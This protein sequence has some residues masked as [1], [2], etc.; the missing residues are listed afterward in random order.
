MKEKRPDIRYI[1]PFGETTDLFSVG[2]NKGRYES[3][4][5][6]VE[7][8]DQMAE[9]WNK[10]GERA[11]RQIWQNMG[12][13]SQDKYI[14]GQGTYEAIQNLDKMKEVAVW[15][16]E[17]IGTP[18]FMKKGK[19]KAGWSNDA[20][21]F[22]VTEIALQKY[23]LNGGV[24]SGNPHQEVSMFI[25]PDSKSIERISSA[26]ADIEQKGWSGLSPDMQRTLEAVSQYGE[27][28][29]I[30]TNNGITTIGRHGRK[31][32]GHALGREE[33]LAQ[34]KKGLDNLKRATPIDRAFQ[35]MDGTIDKNTLLAGHNVH[36]FDQRG[37]LKVLAATKASMAKD[38]KKAKQT[39]AISNLYDNLQR[40]QLDT[41]EFF[42][43][44]YDR[45]LHDFG[46]NMTL[47]GLYR[48]LTGRKAEQAH[49][50]LAD[51]KMNASL[52]QKGLGD[53]KKTKALDALGT[54]SSNTVTTGMFVFSTKGV[55][56][57]S[58]YDAIYDKD[59][60]GKFIRA[61]D[62][63][64]ASLNKNNMYE[65]V[66]EVQ[67][68]MVKG[69]RQFS[70]MLRNHDT[71]LY[72]SIVRDRFD[73]IA[74]ILQKNTVPVEGNG[75]L[76]KHLEVL[77]ESAA[78]DRARRAYDKLFD[79][80]EGKGT[81][82]IK[83]SYQ[84]LDA[85]ERAYAQENAD[86][87]SAA[88]KR[89]SAI[90]KALTAVNE[91]VDPKYQLGMSFADNTL[92]MQGR[93]IGERKIWERAIE[94]I[95]KQDMWYQGE[96][97]RRPDR[98]KETLALA[99]VK[100]RLDKETQGAKEL[101][102]QPGNRIFQVDVGGRSRSMNMTRRD[103]FLA[104]FNNILSGK[105]LTPSGQEQRFI[106]MVTQARSAEFLS[107][108]AQSQ[109][110]GMFSEM[111]EKGP[112]GTN[113]VRRLGASFHES[114]N[115]DKLPQELAGGIISRSPYQAVAGSIGKAG[116][117]DFF[118]RIVQESVDFARN[119]TGRAIGGNKGLFLS[120]PKKVQER[121]KQHEEG[122]KFALENTGLMKQAPGKVG[123]MIDQ[124]AR[125]DGRVVDLA[126]QFEQNG[127]A[128]RV[129]YA[130]KTGKMYMLVSKVE[131][132]ARLHTMDLREAIGSSSVAHFEIPMMNADG[133]VEI[134]GQRMAGRLSAKMGTN[135]MELTNVVDT[136][137]ENMTQQVGSLHKAKDKADALGTE[138]TAVDLHRRI[139]GRI[140]SVVDGLISHHG[141]YE[142]ASEKDTFRRSKIAMANRSTQI[143]TK[144]MAEQWYKD[145]Q[146]RFGLEDIS[147]VLGRRE[148]GRDMDFFRSMNIEAQ[149]RFHRDI[150]RYVNEELGMNLLSQHGI[151]DNQARNGIRSMVDPREYFAFGE[152]NPTARE[153]IVKG[154]NYRALASDASE[155]EELKQRLRI[156]SILGNDGMDE[157]EIFRALKGPSTTRR[158]REIQ[159]EEVS[160]LNVRVATTN[161]AT[162]HTMV[163]DAYRRV[164]VEIEA[165]EGK[166]DRTLDENRKL[167]DLERIRRDLVNAGKMSTHDG[168]MIAS[169]AMQDAFGVTHEKSVSVGPYGNMDARMKRLL[170]EKG[171]FSETG[172]T[173]AESGQGISFSE[174][175]RA[176]L[177]QKTSGGYKVTVGTLTK[178]END[179]LVEKVV[180]DYR[181]WHRHHEV[182]GFDAET[183]RVIFKEYDR[184]G[185]GAKAI[186]DAGD[187]NTMVFVEQ[188]TI[189]YVLNEQGVRV[190]RNEPEIN[191][192]IG[193][194][195]MSKMTSFYTDEIMRQALS[196]DMSPEVR[197]AMEEVAAKKG[198]TV[199]DMVK[200]G[201]HDE[202]MEKLMGGSLGKYMDLDGQYRFEEGRL[203]LNSRL[204][205]A[206]TTNG[207]EN[208]FR[209]QAFDKQ[210][211]EVTGVTRQRE[212]FELTNEG[213]GKHD[214]YTYERTG[215]VMRIGEKEKA[216]IRSKFSPI[217]GGSDFVDFIERE[218]RMS[219]SRE[220]AAE[221]AREVLD[222]AGRGGA[223]P[224][225][226]DLVID[227]SGLTVGDDVNQIV[228]KDGIDYVDSNVIRQT[229]RATA[230]DVV[231]LADEYAG[232]L[233]NYKGASALVGGERVSLGDA[234][235]KVAWMK[236]PH[237]FGEDR[238]V[239]LLDVSGL[240]RLDESDP[241]LLQVQKSQNAL[242]RNLMELSAV[243][244]GNPD[245][246]PEK[247][248]ELQNRIVEEA[249][250]NIRYLEEDTA[251][252]TSSARDGGL[253]NKLGTTKLESSAQFRA[254]TVNPFDNWSM[255]DGVWQNTGDFKEGTVHISRARMDEMIGKNVRNVADTLFGGETIEEL[256]QNMT[257]EGKK[258]SDIDREL[259]KK[260]LDSLTMGSEDEKALYGLTNRFPTISD[261]T[262]QATRMVI[263]PS[264]DVDDRRAIISVGTLKRMAGDTDGDVIN[265]MLTHYGDKNASRLHEVARK[266][267]ESEV[268]AAVSIGRDIM[269]EYQTNLEESYMAAKRSQGEI[270]A[271]TPELREE[272]ARE[273]RKMLETGEYTAGNLALNGF[274]EKT[275]SQFFAYKATGEETLLAN[276]ARQGKGSLGRIDNTRE[277]MKRL[278]DMTMGVLVEGGLETAA[279]AHERSFAIQKFGSIISQELISSKK[280]SINTFMEQ[281]QAEQ[282]ELTDGETIRNLA[283]ERLQERHIKVNKLEEML[284]NPTQEN[285][286]VLR[287]EL[288]EMGIFSKGN[289]YYNGESFSR[290]R[291]LQQGLDELSYIH[292]VNKD[293]GGMGAKALR[294]NR[295]GGQA[296]ME[297]VDSVLAGRNFLPTEAVKGVYEAAGES[298]LEMFE[299][300]RELANKR[301]LN[302]HEE[303]TRVS[304]AFGEHSSQGTYDM[305]E[306]IASRG[307]SEFAEQSGRALSSVTQAS[308]EIVGALKRGA[309]SPVGISFAAIWGASA[310][311]R[312]G[313]TPEGLE[314]QQEATQAEVDP[315]ILLTSPTARVTNNGEAQVLR[316]SAKGAVD[317]N[318]LAGIVNREIGEMTGMPMQMNLNVNDNRSSLD[319]HYLQETLNQALGR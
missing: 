68:V 221:I 209:V 58:A 104:Q 156:Q 113:E 31:Y 212:N 255:V 123:R 178:I 164:Q 251:R 80:H 110:F 49:L 273:V 188:S 108:E 217:K 267:Y 4:K 186:S 69:E 171:L 28:A 249:E 147:R 76:P 18:D 189:D 190:I 24:M 140:S 92:G 316:V 291:I 176:G 74:S 88:A 73:D 219:S 200:A 254:S 159:G 250:K 208:L 242:A 62:F 155:V 19:G 129:S 133:T 15:D 245:L 168:L 160:H 13:F 276:E 89:Q 244:N 282:P 116:G 199:K 115:L 225:K 81:N 270:K 32:G 232:T 226:G 257:D 33:G 23:K 70:L 231:F 97:G 211:A 26:I 302:R 95:E 236:L 201:M 238:H 149:E 52:L 20:D 38:P 283:E 277:A 151:S 118:E 22:S 265:S 198:M 228:R 39:K 66:S 297:A 150:D 202:A 314:A 183:G 303:L 10:P 103:D 158:A 177:V 260:V 138:F 48:N 132:A 112:L 71:G 27:G 34:V 233:A 274:D 305:M 60:Q 46:T 204:S 286:K 152:L 181:S 127:F 210:M 63:R 214:I 192:K 213:L 252:F 312:T 179:E 98:Y 315:S 47:G 157:D 136:F 290:E 59:A 223:G 299:N 194:G 61:Q 121:L 227:Y 154:M 146:K 224:S 229:R 91:G 318:A 205:G 292:E 77:K 261:T 203:V 296:S 55:G 279:G 262:M 102:A 239:R 309:V 67:E 128:A 114:V 56:G 247:R 148:K 2:G 43:T 5:E 29:D 298:A 45:P 173:R 237:M 119:H 96:G 106:Q 100:T 145:N 241:M 12:M 278:H 54:L 17:T 174:L 7:M 85:F 311:M 163:K 3:D 317:H 9:A 306:R 248:M 122:V 275:A 197:Q 107:E 137:F 153:N 135:G 175:E 93:L 253:I 187:R 165:L 90:Q 21:F 295:S 25:R 234:Q 87:L 307:G 8:A 268:G 182:T 266:A 281:I 310:L 269:T 117:Q 196:G 301:I 215:D 319:Q 193:G 141:R 30:T 139:Q 105:N 287:S 180:T 130:D 40:P 243:G 126:N 170:E 51:I 308:G 172:L 6:Y 230:K 111:R 240:S 161:E 235:E 185:Q 264:L 36:N 288:N 289:E 94:E 57:E 101:Y 65:V 86:G 207:E 280:L 124:S 64:T 82:R 142:Y 143:D 271:I 184:A 162:I 218:I 75:V 50:A 258:R 11:K 191:K 131:D 83:K 304:R 144:A 195:Y 167:R 169:R 84:F 220:P 16:M 256:V 259:R 109:L 41:L 166:A 263:D 78:K 246:T 222:F 1:D 313:P 284:N 134:N 272:A 206:M 37:I 72:H 79:P 293:V 53:V 14:G 125:L 285:I 42:R 294:F 35:F 216:V 99:G 44:F 300:Q 120:A